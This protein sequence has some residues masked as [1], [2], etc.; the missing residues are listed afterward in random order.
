MV[1]LQ[2][3]LT[4]YTS[5]LAEIRTMLMTMISSSIPPMEKYG[6]SPAFPTIPTD[7]RKK[8]LATLGLYPLRIQTLL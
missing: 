6:F 2:F 4:K 5:N 3:F 8:N 1:S 7:F